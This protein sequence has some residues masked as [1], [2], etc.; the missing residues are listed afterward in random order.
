MLLVHPVLISADAG[1]DLW[2]LTFAQCILTCM[3]TL[4]LWCFPSFNWCNHSTCTG[5]GCHQLQLVLVVLFHPATDANT[6]LAL[7][8][9]ALCGGGQWWWLLYVEV[10]VE[11][12]T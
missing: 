11:V 5:G 6:V 4:C 10:E 7:G 1:P 9:L 12:D 3:C 2:T 8:Q